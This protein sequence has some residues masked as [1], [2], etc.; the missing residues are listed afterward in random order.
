MCVSLQGVPISTS[1]KSQGWPLLLINGAGMKGCLG[2][3]KVRPLPLLEPIMGT[4]H[5][6]GPLRLWK[7]TLCNPGTRSASAPRRDQPCGSSRRHQQ[8]SVFSGWQGKLLGLKIASWLLLCLRAERCGG[9]GGGPA[10]LQVPFKKY[11]GENLSSLV[12]RDWEMKPLL[13]PP[14]PYVAVLCVSFTGTLARCCAAQWMWPNP[15]HALCRACNLLVSACDS[16]RSLDAFW[17]P[18]PP[19]ASLPLKKNGFRRDNE[20]LHAGTSFIVQMGRGNTSL[21]IS[22][23]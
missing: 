11:E 17:Q 21:K 4:Q 2:E 22:L 7:G 19:S 13:P 15:F 23:W 12:C 10:R 5:G 3:E 9:G 6:E 16:N 8:G 1:H 14:P 18:P 20:I